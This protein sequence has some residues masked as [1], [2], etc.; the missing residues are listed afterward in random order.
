[1]VHLFVVSNYSQY[2][3]MLTQ[4]R[5]NG[6]TTAD[7]VIGLGLVSTIHGFWIYPMFTIVHPYFIWPTFGTMWLCLNLG[8]LS[9]QIYIY[10]C[11][12][13][14]WFTSSKNNRWFSVCPTFFSRFLSHHLPKIWGFLSHVMGTPTQ[15]QFP[16]RVRVSRTPIHHHPPSE[17]VENVA[18][19]GP[20][21]EQVPRNVGNLYIYTC[22]C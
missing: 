5:L 2:S 14:K 3:V 16:T 1:M 19:Q 6:L 10:I 8:C 13:N 11:S 20:T 12:L 22:Y 15:P 18:G 4:P 9:S 17:N 7:P 21:F